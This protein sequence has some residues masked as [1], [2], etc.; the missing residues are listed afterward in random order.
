M[1][2]IKIKIASRI[3]IGIGIGHWALGIGHWALGIGHQCH[4]HWQ[5]HFDTTTTTTCVYV[6]N[7]RTRTTTRTYLGPVQAGVGEVGEGGVDVDIDRLASLDVDALEAKESLQ[8]NAVLTSIRG[9]EESKHNVVGI[10][11]ASV[12][13]LDVVRHQGSRSCHNLG[14]W[15]R[16]AS[17]CM[18][19]Y[20]YRYRYRYTGIGIGVATEHK[21]NS[22]IKQTTQMG[23][24]QAIVIAGI[25]QVSKQVNIASFEPTPTSNRNKKRVGRTVKWK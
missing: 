20:R 5:W 16:A 12:L 6:F 7:T 13:D 18:Y 4:W 10:D 24:L 3:G 1:H 23:Q 9:H 14:R 21:T 2:F 22:H 25:G 11:L 19:W 15:E 17:L 8:R